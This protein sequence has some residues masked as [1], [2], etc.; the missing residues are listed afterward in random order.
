MRE[1][2]ELKE[3]DENVGKTRRTQKEG[4]VAKSLGDEANV[5]ALLHEAV[6][7][8]KHMNEIMTEEELRQASTYCARR[9]TVT[10]M[11]REASNVWHIKGEGRPTMIG[12]TQR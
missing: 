8:V 11:R 4:I 7:E 9:R 6:N 1:D 10:I 3:L 2:P 12:I 5:R